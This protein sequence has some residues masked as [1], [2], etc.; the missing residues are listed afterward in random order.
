MSAAGASAYGLD[1]NGSM[2]LLAYGKCHVRLDLQ[3]PAGGACLPACHPPAR[4]P[5]CPPSP[6]N[7]H[8]VWILQLST[9]CK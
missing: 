3:G 2:M 8:K 5:A 7:T 6:P 4:P 9:R 1:G